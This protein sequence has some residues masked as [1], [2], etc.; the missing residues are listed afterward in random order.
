MNAKNLGTPAAIVSPPLRIR[1]RP[2]SLLEANVSNGIP[3]IGNDTP[4]TCI[5][6]NEICTSADAPLVSTLHLQSKS[7]KKFDSKDTD[8]GLCLM[9][10]P[11]VRSMVDI[12]FTTARTSLE[13]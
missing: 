4:P 10:L 11:L 5:F 12:S 7:R 13:W 9:T 6:R 3:G 1:T 8:R 2:M